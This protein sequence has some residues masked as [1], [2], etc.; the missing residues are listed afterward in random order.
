MQDRE[1][2]Q[3][4][5]IIGAGIIGLSTAYQL[6]EREC[7]ITIYADAFAPDITSSK[8]A[9]FWFPYHIQNDER[10]IRWSQAS[11]EKYIS[12]SADPA[13]G[14]SRQRLL[15]MVKEEDTAADMSWIDFIPE[16]GCRPLDTAELK[17]GFRL[18]HEVQVP[19]IETQHFLPWLV[20]QLKDKGV[21]FVQKHITD[22]KELATEYSR[23]INCSGLGARELCADTSIYPAR[24]QV[25][26]VG[27]RQ[28][29]PLFLCEEQPFYIVPRQD[30]TIIGGT[31][32]EGEWDLRPEPDIIQG[33]YLQAVGLFPRLGDSPILNSWSG[34]R[35]YRKR[36]RVEQEAGTNIIHNYGH[37]GSG[38]TL[39]WGCAEKVAAMI[40]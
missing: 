10:C 38:F 39:A 31:Y 20:A 13:T 37:G 6:L 4:I 34:L 3:N 9:A 26:L 7:A 35:P 22:L 29:M 27:A 25:A 16:N 17:K 28:D 33:L 15:K 30:F 21:R 19:L 12:L 18:G 2:I 24:G 14:I 23:V 32:E 11:Y 40:S 5:A 8:A 1:N 36:I